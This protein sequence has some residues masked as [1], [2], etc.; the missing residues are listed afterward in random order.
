[1]ETK[2]IG[3]CLVWC[4]ECDTWKPPKAARFTLRKIKVDSGG[5][6]NKGRH[7][8]GVG[9]PPLYW[10]SSPEDGETGYIRAK[11]RKEAM[12]KVREI[13][14]HAKFYGEAS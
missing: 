6:I 5:Y 4:G 8:F 3:V 9:S 7:Y 1:M 13:Y 2:C 11:S 14:P 10:W 12:D